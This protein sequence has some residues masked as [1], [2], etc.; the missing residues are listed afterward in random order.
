[1][2]NGIAPIIIFSFPVISEA[3]QAV[4]SQIPVI[5]QLLADNIAIPIPIYLDQNLT[6]IL[7]ESESKAL[8]IDTD[9]KQKSNG[10]GGIIYQR[11]INNTVTINMLASK[12]STLLTV[13]FALADQVFSRLVARNYSITYMNGSTTVFNGLLHGFSTNVTS[14]DDMLRVTLQLAKTESKGPALPTFSQQ[15]N[16]AGRGVIP[17]TGIPGA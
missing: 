8:D 12:D 10:K 16:A 7:I 9:P 2:L 3:Q 5:G 4:I 1:M 11:G 6:G 14:D 15:L 17:P 13:L